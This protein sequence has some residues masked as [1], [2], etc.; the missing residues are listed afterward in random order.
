M[1]CKLGMTNKTAF[2]DEMPGYEDGGQGAVDI[3]LLGFGKA[4]NTISTA[5]LERSCGSM[6]WKTGLFGEVKTGWTTGLQ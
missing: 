4:F 3:R 1:K 5:L 6:G 2:C